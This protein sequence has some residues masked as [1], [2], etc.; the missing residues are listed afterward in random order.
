MDKNTLEESVVDTIS[1][2]LDLQSNV[3]T[4]KTLIDDVEEWDSLAHINIITQLEKEFNFFAEIDALEKLY[5]VKD[6][7]D[8]I[9]RKSPSL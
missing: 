6:I 5:S 8:L 4:V 2:I 3:I 7:I 9:E 1:E